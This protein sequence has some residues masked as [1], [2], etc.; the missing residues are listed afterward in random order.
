MVGSIFLVHGD[1]PSVGK[2]R[3]LYVEPDARGT[4]VGKLLVSTRI[5]QAC[6]VGYETLDLWT[7]SVLTAARSLYLRVRFKLV[8]E[9][10]H[11]SFKRDLVGQALSLAL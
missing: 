7:N 6:A 3:L 2:L 8:D 1:Q 9:A 10:P 5:E 4:G 11:H